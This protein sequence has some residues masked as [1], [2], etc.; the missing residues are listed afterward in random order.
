[1]TLGTAAT[2]VIGT[3]I[4]DGDFR[5]NGKAAQGRGSLFDGSEVRAGAT[6]ATIRLAE[7]AQLDLASGS[8]GRVFRDRVV[9]EQG[10]GQFAA[11][12]GYTLNAL[13]L[14]V[15]PLFSR[16][17][18]RVALL[19]S[20]K[21]QLGVLTGLWRV[22][23][24]NG[25]IVA[26][27]TPGMAVDLQ[28]PEDKLSNAS[29]MKGCL[30]KK[31][32]RY[33]LKDETTN[34]TVELQAADPKTLEDEVGHHIEITGNLL[35]GATP[36][37]DATQLIQISELKRLS[38]RCGFPAGMLAGTGIASAAIIAGI[39]IGTGAAIGTIVAVTSNPSTP[40]SPS[41]P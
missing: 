35:A 4:S 12:P 8:Q 20:N 28:V 9:L 27:I 38:K 36:V 11:S 15:T 2:P 24:S 18:G 3:V 30:R 22:A 5:L 19:E 26:D 37:K 41:Q 31:D 7:G 34:V 10:A 32:G 1:M 40:V 16:A 33:L 14:Q 21:V 39:I 6:P 25:V 29:K 17:S 23:N 13:T